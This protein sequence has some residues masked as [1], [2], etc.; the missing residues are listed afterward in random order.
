MEK[1][2]SLSRGKVVF[3]KILRRFAAPCLPTSDLFNEA[4]FYPA[5]A[6]DLKKCQKEVIIESPFITANRM[7][8]LLPLLKVLSCRGIEITINTRDPQ[9]HNSPY[10]HQAQYAIED[11]IDLG[12][13]VLFTGGHHRKLAIIDRGILWEGSLNILSQN[14]SCEIMRRTESKEVVQ[15]MLH[16]TKLD[17]FLG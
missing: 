12:A 9:E 16:F 7:A 4:T 8:V 6:R 2:P 3:N 14:D 13:R 1:Y 17:K 11:L 15:Q 5:F 10:D